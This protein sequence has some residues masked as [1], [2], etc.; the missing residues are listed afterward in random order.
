MTLIQRANKNGLGSQEAVPMDGGIARHLII[1]GDLDRAVLG[2]RSYPQDRGS[3][4]LNIIVF[5]EYEGR[6]RELVIDENHLSRLSVGCASLPCESEILCNEGSP[7]N[8]RQI[9]ARKSNNEALKRM[10]I[11][12]ELDFATHAL[13][14]CHNILVLKPS[15]YSSWP[16]LSARNILP[17]LVIIS[18]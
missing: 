12:G 15:F 9:Q 18:T 11:N 17:K 14:I 16:N 1:H 2:N 3:A 8:E 5:V 7:G 4:Y 13:Q 6:T 10:H